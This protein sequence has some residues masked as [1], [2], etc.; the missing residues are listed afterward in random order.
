MH[1][2]TQWHKGRKSFKK[3]IQKP[4]EIVVNDVIPLTEQI[5]LAE[6]IVSQNEALYLIGPT[7]V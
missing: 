1:P 2:M 3:T 6:P 5:N 4:D 7:G